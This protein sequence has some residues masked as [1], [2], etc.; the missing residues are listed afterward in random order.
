[1]CKRRGR[2]W[3]RH[4]FPQP[5]EAPAMTGPRVNRP[6]MIPT[7]YSAIFG[8]LQYIADNPALH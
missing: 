5:E 3:F 7:L 6:S 4:V 8:V 2:S 1:M